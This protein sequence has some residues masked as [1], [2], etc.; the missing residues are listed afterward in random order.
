LQIVQGRAHAFRRTLVLP[1]QGRVA[2]T[3]VDSCRIG[4]PASPG[5]NDS[6]RTGSLFSYR[7]GWQQSEDRT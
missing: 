4:A 7:S 3:G 6:L 1:N 5:S 2:P